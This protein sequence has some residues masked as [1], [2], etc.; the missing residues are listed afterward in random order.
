MVVSWCGPLIYPL[1]PLHTLQQGQIFG[2]PGSSQV[3]CGVKSFKTDDIKR[4]RCALGQ[5]MSLF[6]LAVCNSSGISCFKKWRLCRCAFV[7]FSTAYSQIRRFHDN[8]NTSDQ[9]ALKGDILKWNIW[10]WDFNVNV[11]TRTVLCLKA[12]PSKSGIADDI[13]RKFKT[14]SLC[15]LFNAQRKGVEEGQ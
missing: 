8:R 7:V 14:E 6:L 15:R 5:R 10:K 11:H 4:I 12:P 2:L 3:C 13:A 1:A 9:K